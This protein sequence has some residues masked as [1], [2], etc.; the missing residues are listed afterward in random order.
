MMHGGRSR[1]MG[2]E[3]IKCMNKYPFKQWVM[4]D[5]NRCA[6]ENVCVDIFTFVFHNSTFL[7]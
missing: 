5:N 4:T 7:L 2:P 1:K 6:I 3:Y